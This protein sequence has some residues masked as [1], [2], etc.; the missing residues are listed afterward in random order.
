M[1]E[2]NNFFFDIPFALSERVLRLLVSQG[3]FREPRQGYFANNRLSN[4]IK[5]DQG[6]Y[7]IATYML[8]F[9]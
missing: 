1:R 5:K 6:G 2:K 4:L 3:W 8:V 9:E 7:H